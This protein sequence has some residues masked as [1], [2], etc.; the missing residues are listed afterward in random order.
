MRPIRR[1]FDFC[2]HTA[3]SPITGTRRWQGMI[4]VNI[5]KNQRAE[6][7]SEKLFVF[8]SDQLD[9]KPLQDELG[10]NENVKKCVS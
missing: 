2:S 3:S 1:S 6:V 8:L 5:Q 7:G 4:V 10:L 9:I